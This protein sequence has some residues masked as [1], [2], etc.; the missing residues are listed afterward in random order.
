MINSVNA[1]GR[2]MTFKDARVLISDL[3]THHVT[4][5]RGFQEQMELRLLTS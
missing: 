3:Q 4:W 5:Q 2:I 1:M